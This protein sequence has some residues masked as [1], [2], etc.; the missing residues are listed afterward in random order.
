MKKLK[1]TLFYIMV[2]LLSGCN[3]HDI[4][5]DKISAQEVSFDIS[6]TKSWHNITSKA[7]ESGFST[8][9][10]I[11]IFA[12]KR[13]VPLTAATPA[14]EANYAHNV[15]WVYDGSK[16]TPATEKDKIYYP[17][18]GTKLDF[19]AY[20]PYSGETDNPLAI[21]I[22]AGDRQNLE[23]D[24]RMS[25]F[26]TAANITGING[27][28]NISLQFNHRFVMIE[29][30]ITADAGIDLSDIGKVGLLNVGSRATLSLAGNTT[31]IDER[32]D[33]VMHRPAAGEFKWNAIIPAQNIEAGTPFF[34]YTLSTGSDNYL[35]NITS[36]RKFTD[37]NL[38]KF[39]IGLKYEDFTVLK[40][41]IPTGTSLHWSA[42][43]VF[44]LT[45]GTV[46][47]IHEIVP[48]GD[49]SYK[50]PKLRQKNR[51]IK[52]SFVT[53]GEDKFDYYFSNI[54]LTGGSK[55][56]TLDPPRVGTYWAGGI[57][58]IVP[59]VT[60][61]ADAYKGGKVISLNEAQKAWGEAVN[62]NGATSISGY[63]NTTALI[64]AFPG[65]DYAANWC[66]N[67]ANGFD[68]NWFLPAEGE[69]S[70]FYQIYNGGN[71]TPA[72]QAARTLF[73]G[74]L[75]QAGGTAISEYLHWSSTEEDKNNARFVHLGS[76][77]SGGE[78]KTVM[79][80]IRSIRSF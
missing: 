48:S 27:D 19:Y 36:G 8:G 24:F 4:E 30:S 54:P 26:M 18:D 37:G 46:T 80:K 2:L 32:S 52:A 72:N 57:V 39:N 76:P 71:L 17:G 44:T 58:Y 34:S 78:A 67:P 66:R 11:G 22:G 7:N 3:K 75:T 61:G 74:Y 49:G 55:S 65:K 77:T 59:P 21:S 25:D 43:A 64:K 53:I 1:C 51:L 29:V 12:V 5:T 41:T 23:Q 15:K 35:H 50:F 31:T 40:F 62:V 6:G 20:Y 9:D 56:I 63:A 69:L 14:A 28:N 73:N 68:A 45:D 79:A 10:S 33:I 47:K 42:P 70:E 16:W 38:Y 60:T 13:T